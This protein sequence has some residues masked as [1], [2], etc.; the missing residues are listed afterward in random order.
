MSEETEVIAKVTYQNLFR[1]FPNLS[2]MTGTAL[3][4]AEDFLEVYGLK[5]FPIPTALPVARRDNDDAVF[6]TKEGKMKALLKN[7]LSTHE[8]GRPILIGTTSVESS[9]EMVQALTDL[10]IENVQVL[11]ARPENVER[12]SEIVSQAGRL[13]VLQI[14]PEEKTRY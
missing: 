1:L 6:R 12:E 3:T 9:E 8:K 11:N 2:G 7:V 10:G 14:S 4:E 5:V 13:G